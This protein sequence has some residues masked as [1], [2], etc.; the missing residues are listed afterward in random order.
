MYYKN[1][2][3]AIKEYLFNCSSNPSHTLTERGIVT[4]LQEVKGMSLY[5]A[6]ETFFNLFTMG[7]IYGAMNSNKI[8]EYVIF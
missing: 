4:I 6:E 8:M 3:V 1:L 5:D 7:Y 2:L